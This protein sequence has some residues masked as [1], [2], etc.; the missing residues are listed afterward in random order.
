MKIE[1]Y[2]VKDIKLGKFAQPFSAPN[3]EIAKRMLMSTVNA[4]GNQINE[5][6]EDFQMF[7]LGEYDEDTGELTSGVEFVINAIELKKEDKE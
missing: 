4:K 3:K 2:C 1:L 7:K 5:F 6:P